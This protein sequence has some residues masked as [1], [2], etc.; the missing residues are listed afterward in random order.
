MYYVSIYALTRSLIHN[1]FISGEV[2]VAEPS[3]SGSLL[4]C[5]SPSLKGR[6]MLLSA[7]FFPSES[8]T[9]DPSDLAMFVKLSHELTLELVGSPRRYAWGA[10]T[11]SDNAPARNRVWPRETTD[12]S[13]RTIDNNAEPTHHT[14][15]CTNVPT[16]SLRYI[17]AAVQ[18][19][20]LGHLVFA[21]SPK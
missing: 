1:T 11:E 13:Q 15:H 9:K 4:L 10:Y 21:Q 7:R 2:Q 6:W 19:D 20:Y 12:T 16:T 5:S 3:Q 18:M 17:S 8:S 14:F